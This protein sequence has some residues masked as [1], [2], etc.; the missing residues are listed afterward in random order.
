M[1]M[2]TLTAGVLAISLTVTSLAPT[3]AAADISK[4]DA[5]AGILTLLFFLHLNG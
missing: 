4:D 3:S 1:I 5:I 2:K